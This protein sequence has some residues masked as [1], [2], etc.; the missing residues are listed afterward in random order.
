MSDLVVHTC[1]C[2][3]DAKGTRCGR[4]PAHRVEDTDGPFW[5]CDECEVQ[6]EDMV[7]RIFSACNAGRDDP[8]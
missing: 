6:V 1:Q 7:K 2:V 8:E 5:T 3:I 4:T